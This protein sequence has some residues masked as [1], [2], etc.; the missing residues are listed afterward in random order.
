MLGTV[1]DIVL[2]EL[3]GCSN[4]FI[5]QTRKRLGI[6]A[7]TTKRGRN[8]IPLP[9]GVEELLGK[10]G[11]SEIASLGG[12]H[13]LTARKWRIERGIEPPET[14]GSPL[15][16]LERL[17]KRYPGITEKLGKLSDAEVGRM[18]S[19]SRE[20]IR[21]FRTV[22]ELPTYSSTQR[23]ERDKDVLPL[24]GVIPLTEIAERTGIGFQTLNNL[25]KKNQIPECLSEGK[26]ESARKLKSIEHRLGKESDIKLEREA[27]ISRNILGRYRNSLGI[28]PFQLSPRCEGFVKLEP[29]QVQELLDQGCSLRDLSNI[30]N[31]SRGYLYAFITK[32]KLTRPKESYQKGQIQANA[33]RSKNKTLKEE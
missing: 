32:H 25:R 26:L 23:E 1:P 27:G 11:D 22:L 20:Y 30:L 4:A 17:E 14:R 12:V 13:Y 21:Q 18:Y 15:E 3:V 31:K 19:L 24:L 2:A 7:Q 8:K 16:Y 9:E 28:P 5:F 6:P 33:L 10:R 29:S